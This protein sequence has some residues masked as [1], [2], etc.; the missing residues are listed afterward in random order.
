MSNRLLIFK[1][2]F[3]KVRRA[4]AGALRRNATAEGE[5]GVAIER[6]AREWRGE[7]GGGGWLEVPVDNTIN[8]LP[9]IVKLR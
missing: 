4:N 3:A 9:R 5:G 8:L 1:V 7:G 2:P 6:W